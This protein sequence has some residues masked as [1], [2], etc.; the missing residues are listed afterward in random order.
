M[1]TA[2][3]TGVTGQDGCYLAPRLRQQG[4][5]V[6][7]LTRQ[8]PEAAAAS[9]G[10]AAEGIE[11][12]RADV[13]DA[14]AL[15]ALLRRVAPHEI[16]HLASQSGVRA[17]WDDPVHTAE[18]TALG[19]LGVLEAVRAEAPTARL[20]MASSSEIFGRPPQ[21]PQSETTPVAPVTPYGASKAFAYH[22]TCSYRDVH[23]L[24]AS[25]AILFNHE[26]PRRG[27]DFV[28]RKITAGVARIAA[29]ID[30]ELPLG[31]LE[32]R[33]DWGFAGDYA[34]AMWRMLQQAS[35]SDFVIG[36]GETHS[37]REFCEAAFGAAGLD[38]RQHVVED[39]R[40]LRPADARTLVA[41]ARRAHAKLGWQTTVTFDALVR[42]MVEADLRRVEGGEVL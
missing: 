5:R 37:V 29:G 26:S 8:A 25:S 6:V 27:I 7:G 2:L 28:T 31:N 15:V 16:Y 34:D 4:Y 3:I 40:F 32:A 12:A 20:L 42:M 36:T 1:P 11:F 23:G 21:S 41:D 35:P 13:R 24:H 14:A 39:E 19:A 18:V 38:Y 30:R 17:S 33:R 10:D 22:L 9:M